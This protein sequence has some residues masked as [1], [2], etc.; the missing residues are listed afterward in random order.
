MQ[1]TA[2]EISVIDDTTAETSRIPSLVSLLVVGVVLLLLSY[3]AEAMNSASSAMNG[4]SLVWLSN[5]MLIGVLL[6]AP[7]RQWPAYI[8]LAYGVDLTLN[9]S[10]GNALAGAAY[11]S[12]CN[13]IEATI[14]ASLIAPVTLRQPDFTKAPQLRSFLLYGTLLAPA[15]TAALATLYLWL[16][17]GIP[18]LLSF[19]H[20]FAADVVGIATMTPL[21]VSFHQGKRFSQ[22]DWPEITGLFVLLIVTAFACFRVSSYPTL[23]LVLLVLLL[24]GVRLGFTGS[25]AGLLAVIF[26]GGYLTIDG[27]GPLGSILPA[28]LPNRILFLQVFIALTMIALYC[29]E[30]A[31]SANRRIRASLQASESRFRSLAEASR[32]I[33]VLTNLEGDRQYISPAITELLGWSDIDMVGGTFGELSHADDLPR[34]RRLVKKLLAGL[35]TGSVAYQARKQDGS[36]L[37]LEAT[38]RLLLNPDTGLP[39]GI[40]YVLRD[41]S[42]RKAAEQ[43]LM[44][45]FETAEKLA[46]MDGLTGLANRRLLDQTLTG[47]WSRAVR[48]HAPLSLLL[49]DVDYFKPYNDI[50]GHLEGDECLRVIANAV[51]TVLQRPT[52]LLARYGGEEFVVVLPNTTSDGARQLSDTIRRVI[53]QRAI[54]HVGSTYAVVTVSIGCA[55]HTPAIEDNVNN[56]LMAADAALYRAK[57][58]GRNR[59]ALAND[60]PGHPDGPASVPA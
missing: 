31:M 8:F 57:F 41:I 32:D 30:V 27:R 42:D 35:P 16:G 44:R 33:I 47:E 17:N 14:A 15:V 13:M 56:L 9:L 29:T 1:Q 22:R 38:G 11:F 7:R 10:L 50:Y 51:K 6:C 2:R 49:I 37:W 58:T 59:V 36:Y 34:L 23:W 18:I 28:P 19:R 48:A 20:W 21:Y 26:I 39:H 24:L 60:T 4:V 3:T 45:A 25:A 46:M 40:V 54:P 5:G 12:F 43:S 55:T 53:E 52:D